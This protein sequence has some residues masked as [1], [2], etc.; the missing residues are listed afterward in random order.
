ALHLLGLVSDGGVHSHITHLGGLLELAR[1]RALSRV[2][3]HAF[4]DGR[5]TPPRSALRY[6]EQTGK[7]FAESGVG[8]C[9]TV[10]GR[11]YAMDRDQRWDRT[12]SA[13]RAMVRGEGEHAG[14]FREAVERG[15]ERGENDEFV[16]P[17]VVREGGVPVATIGSGDAC[18]CFNFRPDRARQ[19]TRALALED[20]PFERP[21]RPRD[22]GYVC[23]T[24]YQ[25]E[26]GLPIAF[27][28]QS[29]AGTLGA[30]H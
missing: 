30:A 19:I 20:V 17:T 5:D 3:L 14:S 8:R 7:M 1:R 21:D 18:V 25:A 12:E 28:P 4:L 6:V 13:Y 9:A 15:Y 27:P 23:F 16:K 2:Y 22:L 10:S 11:Y 26:F 24:R 29:V